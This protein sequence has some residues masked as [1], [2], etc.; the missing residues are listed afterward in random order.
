MGHF[1]KR[2]WRHWQDRRIVQGIHGTLFYELD[3]LMQYYP[4]RTEAGMILPEVDIDALVFGYKSTT[5]A[6]RQDP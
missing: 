3:H 1:G 2:M 5:R 6:T 4:D